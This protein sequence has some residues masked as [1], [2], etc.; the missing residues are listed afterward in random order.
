MIPIETIPEKREGAIKKND[1]GGEFKYDVF[2][3]CKYCK[4]FC[5]CHDVPLPRTKI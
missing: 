3:T 5:E 4:N 2:K 1:E